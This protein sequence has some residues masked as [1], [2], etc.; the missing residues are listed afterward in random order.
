MIKSLGLEEIAA[1]AGSP[2]GGNPYL[3]EMTMVS[4]ALLLMEPS[5]TS[6]E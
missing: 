3:V 2:F 4:F 1:G 5:K 6:T